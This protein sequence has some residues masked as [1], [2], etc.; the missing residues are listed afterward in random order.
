MA[1]V[2]RVVCQI[3]V[4]AISDGP[5]HLEAAALML[6]MTGPT[7]PRPRLAIAAMELDPARNIAANF[8][9]TIDA[10]AGFS[11]ALEG[12]VAR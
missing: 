5:D 1:A 10:S 11:R 8:I 2:Q 6:R 12:S 9:M 4:E 7:G 3:V